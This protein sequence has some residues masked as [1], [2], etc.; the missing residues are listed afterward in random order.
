MQL[1]NFDL[2]KQ[3]F[4]HVSI[5]VLR[6]FEQSSAQVNKLMAC[7]TLNSLNTALAL[8]MHAV[9]TARPV[10]G[11]ENTRFKG[12]TRRQRRDKFLLAG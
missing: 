10:A 7:N 9:G 1:L 8:V 4:V 2:D 12:A 3:T 5:N 11:V 6:Q